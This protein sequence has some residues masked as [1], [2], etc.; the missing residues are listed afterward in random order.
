VGG[1]ND[2]A[3]S[4]KHLHSGLAAERGIRAAKLAHLGLLAA[5]RSIEG[6]R[7][8]LAALACSRAPATAAE[9][10]EPRV[11]EIMLGGLGERWA[12]LRN[13]YKRYP[14]CLACFEPLEGIR[15]IME[16]SER[17]REEVHS[18]LLE[19][20]PRSASIVSQPHPRDQ[21]QAK[22]SATFAASLVLA[23]YNP[24]DLTLPPEWL[25]DPKVT[26]W[27]SCIQLVAAS[28]VPR[29]HA[30]VTVRWKDGTEERADRPL[31]NLDE[32]EVWSRFAGACRQCLGDRANEVEATVA[33][34]ADLETTADLF[35]LARLVIGL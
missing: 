1:H 34:C 16:G 2:E 19:L 8:F 13:I 30:R 29:R 22:F 23:G 25:V 31:R 5:K 4:G 18:V 26:N 21:L 24:E 28:T 17:R 20:Y 11:R 27:Y 35:A 6:D 3:I 32:A 14:F 33:R 9:P 15:S 7:G 10:D 12:I